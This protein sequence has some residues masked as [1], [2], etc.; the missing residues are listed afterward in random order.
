[1][2]LFVGKPCFCRP[3]KM[4]GSVLCEIRCI[5]LTFTSNSK[6]GESRS[7]KYTFLFISK[8]ISNEA[9]NFKPQC[10]VIGQY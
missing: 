6:Y 3:I 1:M 7:P 10:L 9:Q 4:K 2:W 5:E 8:N